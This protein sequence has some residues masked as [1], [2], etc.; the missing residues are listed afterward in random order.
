MDVILTKYINNINNKQYLSED[1]INIILKYMGY[2][3]YNNISLLVRPIILKHVFYNTSGNGFTVNNNLVLI[4][5]RYYYVKLT[6][7]KN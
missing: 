3:R 7:L 5:S 6:L 2:V 1:I 4:G